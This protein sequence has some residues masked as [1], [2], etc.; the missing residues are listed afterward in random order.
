MLQA[1]ASKAK[2]VGIANAGGDTINAI[3]QGG[4]FGLV[5]GGQRLAALLVFESDAESLGLP[6]AQGL[7]TTTAFYWDQNDE[8]RAWT[9]KFR[10]VKRKK[11]P[12][13]TPRWASI[14]PRCTTSRPCRPRAPTSRW[15]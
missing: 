9:K 15:P 1:Q 12:K 6:I 14:A 13:M 5:K 7:V 3:K 10:T 2:I 11:A 4:E 8:T